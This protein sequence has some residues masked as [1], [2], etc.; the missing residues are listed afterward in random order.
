MHHQ[1]LIRTMRC[2]SKVEIDVV[3]GFELLLYPS[4]QLEWKHIAI[5]ISRFDLNHIALINLKR[6]ISMVCSIRF[7]KQLLAVLMFDE[8]GTKTTA[9]KPQIDRIFCWE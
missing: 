9:M 6:C 1:R 3:I 8:I 2:I 7:Q 4:V 5:L